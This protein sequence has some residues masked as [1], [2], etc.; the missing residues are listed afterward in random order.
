MRIIVQNQVQL[1]EPPEGQRIT[2]E[3]AVFALAVAGVAQVPGCTPGI[4]RPV[5]AE[6]LGAAVRFY[7]PIGE[8]GDGGAGEV[9]LQSFDVSDCFD[10]GHLVA[11]FGCRGCYRQV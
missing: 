7:D 6:D 2:F 9:L 10:V 4:E 1:C 8:N 5:D 11:R 3:S